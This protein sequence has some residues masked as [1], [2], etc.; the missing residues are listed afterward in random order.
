MLTRIV[1]SYPEVAGEEGIMR[2]TETLDYLVVRSG[3]CDVELDNRETI[4]GLIDSDAVIQRR[5]NHQRIRRGSE[6]ERW[7]LAL[8]DA[9]PVKMGNKVLGDNLSNIPDSA[10]QS[11][12]RFFDI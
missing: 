10:R 11:R 2:G 6:P 3:V 12:L 7:L 4:K 5:T 9:D 1:Q 8:I